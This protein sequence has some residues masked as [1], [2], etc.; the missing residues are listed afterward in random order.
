M[1]NDYVNF[2]NFGNA[3]MTLFRCVTGENWPDI[4]N[5][6]QSSGGVIISSAYFIGFVMVC[7]F[8][9]LNLFILILIGF[10]ENNYMNKE[11]NLDKFNDQVTIFRQHWCEKT[12]K[13]KG[14]KMDVKDVVGFLSV[15]PEPLGN[16]LFNL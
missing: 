15:I 1:I 16:L 5:D 8:I 9:M 14:E 2:W 12:A 6:V 4:M 11:N 3:M 13:F 7:T 10:V